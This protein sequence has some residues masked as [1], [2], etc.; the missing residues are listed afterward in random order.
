VF[1]STLS[2][3]TPTINDSLIAFKQFR[4]IQF[5]TGW[6]GKGST[7][8]TTIRT[9]VLSF[10]GEIVAHKSI[11]AAFVKCTTAVASKFKLGGSNA[12]RFERVLQM[13]WRLGTE[14]ETRAV[15]VIATAGQSTHN[16]EK[17]ALLKRFNT[18]RPRVAH[19]K[20]RR[21]SVLLVCWVLVGDFRTKALSNAEITRWNA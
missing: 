6:S 2:Q 16:S 8:W 14:E 13:L 9:N 1:K 17:V 20:S 12:H 11:R 10:K 4:A 5:G 7:G 18:N 21:A 15:R 19:F 3:A